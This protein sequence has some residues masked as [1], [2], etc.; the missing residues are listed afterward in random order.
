MNTIKREQFESLHSKRGIPV[1]I[2]LTT[3][4]TFSIDPLGF[5]NFS[6]GMDS[7]KCKYDD[8]KADKK[9][10]RVSPKN[11][12]ANPFNPM[13][14][15][16]LSLG[17]WFALRK[18]TFG[19][20]DSLF[21]GAGQPGSA[22]QRYCDGLSKR[23]TEYMEKVVEFVRPGH[24]NPHG[25][26]KGVATYSTSG[27]TFP[28]S[29]VSVARRGEWTQG[30]IF[31]IYLQFAEPGDQ[32]LGRLIV[33]LDPNSPNFDVLPPHFKG[34]TDN[35]HIQRAMELC[36]GPIIKAFNATHSVKGFILLCLASMVYHSDFLKSF[37][38]KNPEHPFGLI[39]ILN[40]DVLLGKSSKNW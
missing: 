37:V 12:Y 4:E 7:V 6:V 26:R 23:L 35:E 22:S 9:G 3:R 19:K 25:F 20:N 34:G 31:D 8:S 40:D 11:I 15:P 24:A 28:A 5:H 10:E 30:S 2:S 32:Y 17:C 39:P 16:H 18:G 36:F 21:L 1:C 33:G 27:T 14:C 29:L 38:A 13:V